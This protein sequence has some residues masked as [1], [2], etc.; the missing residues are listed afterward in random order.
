MKKISEIRLQ[1]A[2]HLANKLGSKAEFARLLEMSDSYMWQILGDKQIRN[3]GNSIARRMEKACDM[4]EGW[5]D[6]EHIFKDSNKKSKADSENNVKNGQKEISSEA[7][8]VAQAFDRIQSSAQRKAVIAQ[9][10][11]FGIWK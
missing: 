8:Q 3:I 4:P 6:T 2:L 5:L 10:Q 1:N 9:L 11:A 7:L